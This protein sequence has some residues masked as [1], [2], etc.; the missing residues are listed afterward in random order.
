MKRVPASRALDYAGT[1]EPDNGHGTRVFE[2]ARVWQ[3]DLGAFD[4]AARMLAAG[5]PPPALV[6]GIARG[7]TEL[8]RF[9]GAWFGVP[10]STV[11]ARHNLGDGAYAEMAGTVEVAGVLP[12]AVGG[13]VLIADDICGS[14]DT[15]TAVTGYVA[16]RLGPVAIRTVSLCRNNGAGFTPD[17]WVWSVADWVAFPWEQPPPG[18]SEL[19]AV[20]ERLRLKDDL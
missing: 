20:P 5:E 9:L 15:F 18:H 14:G 2:H 7:G 12:A 4:A 10:V 19:L 6:V 8:G 3:L 11:T 13:G 16:A 17:A 1:A